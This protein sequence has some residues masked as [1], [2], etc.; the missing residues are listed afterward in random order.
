MARIDKILFYFILLSLLIDIVS[1]ALSYFTGTILSIGQLIKIVVL[2]LLILRLFQSKKNS[3]ICLFFIIYVCFIVIKLTLNFSKYQIPLIL[4]DLFISL[5]PLY[6]FA[7]Y[8]WLKNQ[9][10]L[11]IIS[12]LKIRDLVN[13]N[14]YF[15]IFNQIIGLLGFGYPSYVVG[16][17]AIGTSGFFFSGNEYA[18]ILVL[19]FSLKLFFTY[20][21]NNFSRYIY[22][23]IFLIGIAL[24][25]AVKTAIIGTVLISFLLPTS[26]KVINLLKLLLVSFGLVILAG[27]QFL[28]FN[29]NLVFFDR[30]VWIYENKGLSTL[31]VSG[32]DEFLQKG[33]YLFLNEYSLIEQFVGVGYYRLNQISVHPEMDM[34][35]V[36]FMFG[37]LGLIIMYIPFFLLI[38]S[39]IKVFKSDYISRYITLLSLL[40]IGISFFAGHVM[41]SVSAAPF[42]TIIL[43]L[44]Y[45]K[46]ENIIIV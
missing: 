27:A 18:L 30:L 19:I 44:N 23:S 10:Q 3:I 4:S 7:I 24:T 12:N 21:N 8:F 17:A 11:G 42:I 36:L 29:F 46:N 34:F 33:L 6:V 45:F 39:K 28:R 26:L 37:F 38:T 5:K 13:Y 22:W 14:I 43:T 31:L 15:I 25:T 40:I 20:K 32:R 9:I 1:G 35:D 2:Q 16:D 41:F